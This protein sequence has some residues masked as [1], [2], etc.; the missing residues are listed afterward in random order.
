MLYADWIL[1][2]SIERFEQALFKT[3]TLKTVSLAFHPAEN[4]VLDLLHN[5]LIELWGVRGMRVPCVGLSFAVS[6]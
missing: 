1:F 5:Y 6:D 2:G 4:M 3:A